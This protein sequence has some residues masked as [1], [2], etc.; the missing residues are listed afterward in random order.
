MTL[1]SKVG[2]LLAAVAP[3]AEAR[4]SVLQDQGDAAVD[5]RH[6]TLLPMNRQ[7]VR[8]RSHVPPLPIVLIG[9]PASSLWAALYLCIRVARHGRAPAAGPLASCYRRSKVLRTAAQSG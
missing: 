6:H 4:C 5:T 1:P 8:R 7:C 2:C 9:F 3:R